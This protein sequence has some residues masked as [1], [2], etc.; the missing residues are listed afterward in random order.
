MADETQTSLGPT[1]SKRPP[2]EANPVA[3]SGAAR[4]DRADRWSFALT[5][6]IAFAGYWFTLTPD[7]I[8]MLSLRDIRGQC[9]TRVLV[10]KRA[11]RGLDLVLR[12]IYFCG[13]NQ[14]RLQNPTPI[15]F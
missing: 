9:P 13:V 1:E 12:P 10:E 15:I 8:H 4:L 6:T 2:V 5:A 7:V 14:D 3:P 11:P